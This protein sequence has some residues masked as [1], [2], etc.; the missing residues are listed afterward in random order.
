VG[1]SYSEDTTIN[2]Y[3]PSKVFISEK[4]SNWLNSMLVTAPCTAQIIFR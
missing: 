4:D 2:H 3:T 1:T